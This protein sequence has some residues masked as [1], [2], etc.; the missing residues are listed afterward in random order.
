MARF[1]FRLRPVLELRE[2]EEKDRMRIVADLESRRARIESQIRGCQDRIVEGRREVAGALSGGSVDLGAARL[3]SA[4][5][6]RHDQEARRS[7]LELA[8]VMQQLERARAELV[9]AATARRAIELLR[10]RAHERF[11]DEENRRES[12][13]MDDLMVMRRASLD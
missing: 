3:G 7:V 4:A 12:A 5:T 8:G 11:L 6:L 10:D 2:R 9:R 1:V 13:A